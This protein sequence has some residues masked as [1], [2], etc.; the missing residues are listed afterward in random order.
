MDLQCTVSLTRVF[1]TLLFG[2]CYVMWGLFLIQF[3]A[4][5]H[6]ARCP[7]H[8]GREKWGFRD[9]EKQ[10]FGV[11]ISRLS[12]HHPLFLRQRIQ[13]IELP[14]PSLGEQYQVASIAALMVV[15][16]LPWFF[17]LSRWSCSCWL[18]W[19][20]SQESV[21]SQCSPWCRL[22]GREDGWNWAE[23]SRALFISFPWVVLM[24]KIPILYYCTC[25]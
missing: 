16:W 14:L 25:E 11:G 15:W 24:E 23:Q 7:F 17:L 20:G 22:W 2:V 10:L 18:L 5:M 13:Y 8:V 9:V 21:Y 3:T 6:M 12:G 1:S 4:F 19:A